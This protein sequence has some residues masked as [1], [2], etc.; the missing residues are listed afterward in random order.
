MMDLFRAEIDETHPRLARLFEQAK[1]DFWNDSTA[2]DW[3]REIALDPRRRRSLAR[4]L[5]MIYYGERAALEVSAQLLPLVDD[6]EAKFVLAAQVIEEAKHVSAFRK[7]L[8]K[9]DEIHA[10]DPWARRLLADLVRV[11][12]PVAKLL[13][14]QLIVEN[15]ANQLFG[16]IYD[17]IDD[18]LVR[19]VLDYA[20]RDER[21]H[22]ALAVLYLPEVLPRT[23]WLDVKL[24]QARE[25][26][27]MF[28]VGSAIWNHRKDAD[29]IGIDIHAGLQ[30]AIAAQDRLV[31]QMGTRRGI[32]KNRTL[33]NLAL[34]FYKPRKAA[35]VSRP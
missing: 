33:E 29:T 14:M 35:A 13:G 2:I 10:C 30:K 18:P 22:T 27:W 16:Q 34:S 11:R 26:W 25:A 32:F 15:I 19:Q 12:H 5:S 20:A 31:E 7:L 17:A 6:E 1:V 3:D 28:C 4:I 23:S 21:K 9:I 8:K 24:L